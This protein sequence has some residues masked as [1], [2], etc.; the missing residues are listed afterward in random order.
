MSSL[1]SIPMSSA[2]VVVQMKK[3]SCKLVV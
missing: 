3:K 2:I 1:I